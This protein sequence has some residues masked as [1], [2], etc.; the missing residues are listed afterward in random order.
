MAVSE[1]ALE[2]IVNNFVSALSMRKHSM[3]NKRI[4]I[5]TRNFFFSPLSFRSCL[6]YKTSN[7]SDKGA[8]TM[9]R[10]DMLHSGLVF[11]TVKANVT[12]NRPRTLTVA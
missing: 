4:K 8:Q 9:K 1:K 10:L 11:R 3:N 5:I 2:L 7:S 6:T 12:L